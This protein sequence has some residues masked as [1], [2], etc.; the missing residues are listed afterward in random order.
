MHDD[1]GVTLVELAVIVVVL[2]VLAAFVV[3]GLR[4]AARADRRTHCIDGLKQI[5]IYF[6]LY[7]ERYGE[8]PACG[9]GSDSWFAAIWRPEMATDGNLFRCPEIGKGGSGTHYWCVVRGGTLN[10]TSGPFTFASSKDL[11]APATL[12]DFPL[13][14]DA[15]GPAPNHSDGHVDVV[16]LQGR[17]ETF[18][19]S[20]PFVTHPPSFLGPSGW[21]A[22]A[23][24]R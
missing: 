15:M 14:S 9:T 8:F 19:K 23:T 10:S 4:G 21:D 13:A 20:S 18:E 1:R 24:T 11:L 22:P 12:A 16:F 7:R 6:T 17:V 2:A 5:G 3:Q